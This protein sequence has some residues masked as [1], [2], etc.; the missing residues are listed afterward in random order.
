MRTEPDSQ[1]LPE[2]DLPSEDAKTAPLPVVLR[3]DLRIFWLLWADRS[4]GSSRVNGYRPH[5]YLASHRFRSVLLL[6]PSRL[7]PDIPWEDKEHWKVAKLVGSGIVVLQKI[8]GPRTEHLIRVLRETGATTVYVPSD[9][10][11]VI[12]APFLCDVIVCDSKKVIEF[13]RKGGAEN[14]IYIPDPLDFWC[15]RSEIAR[16][17]PRAR[18][19][20]ICWHGS[21]DR[22]NEFLPVREI[23]RE[24]EFAD[25]ELV[26]VSDYPDADVKFSIKALRNAMRKCDVGIVPVGHWAGREYKPSFRV[27]QFMAAGVPVIAERIPSYEE[28][29]THG[30]TGYFAESKD[31][32][33]IAL[34]ALRNP[35]T[36]LQIATRAYDLVRKDYPLEVTGQKWLELFNSLLAKKP[37]AQVRRADLASEASLLNDLLIRAK[38][39]HGIEAFNHFRYIHAAK[40]FTTASARLILHPA[41]FRDYLIPFSRAASRA[42]YLISR[43]ILRRF[44]RVTGRRQRVWKK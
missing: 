9:S 11:P 31:D 6:A 23:L 15:K 40:D 1:D 41:L 20:R 12:H 14:L 2:H 28:V 10:Y 3:D 35:E 39:R 24:P 29:I 36:R 22:W 34:R 19:L 32:Y 7:V 13:Y 8:G 43:R 16:R 18:G 25:M 17:P 4:V 5:E 38:L 37:A 33:R 42:E 30:Q 44:A 26:T 21:R 27:V